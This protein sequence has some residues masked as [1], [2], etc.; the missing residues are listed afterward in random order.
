MDALVKISLAL[1]A[2]VCSFGGA[3]LASNKQIALLSYR[4]E[5][6]EKK[7]EDN[8]VTSRLL[9]LEM[10]LNDVEKK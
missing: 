2:G 3:W 8:D 10:R 4:I 7:F 6:L 5:Q 9:K 1:I